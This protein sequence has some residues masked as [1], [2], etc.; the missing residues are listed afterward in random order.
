MQKIKNVSAVCV[1]SLTRVPF[2]EFAIVTF[3]LNIQGKDSNWVLVQVIGRVCIYYWID[4]GLH[5]F[6]SG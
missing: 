4:L 3:P 6:M 5:L 1:V 2:E